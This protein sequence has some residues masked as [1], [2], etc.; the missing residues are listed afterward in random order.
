MPAHPTETKT[1]RPQRGGNQNSRGGNE[2]DYLM[3]M[4]FGSPNTADTR[5]TK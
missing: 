3:L 1:E 5:M 4:L 2:D